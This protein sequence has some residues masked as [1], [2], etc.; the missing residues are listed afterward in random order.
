V[1]LTADATQIGIAIDR[2]TGSGGTDMYEGL[3]AAD[4]EL[5][6][7]ARV[8]VTQLVVLITDGS[9]TSDSVTQATKMK[10]AGVHIMTVGFTTGVD[11]TKLK[12]LASVRSNSTVKD[13]YF[14][15]EA[16][17]LK[18]ITAF[19]AEETCKI[20]EP[21]PI[22]KP[23][24]PP[25]PIPKITWAE[26]VLACVTGTTES[27]A[28]KTVLVDARG[29]FLDFAV[30]QGGEDV[31]SCQFKF[32]TPDKP[33]PPADAPPTAYNTSTVYS[34]TMPGRWNADEVNQIQC[35]TPP[36][37]NW[38][39]DQLKNVDVRDLRFKATLEVLI[40]PFVSSAN[41]PNVVVGVSYVTPFE[42]KVCC[43]F[44][45]PG[46]WYLFTLLPIFILLLILTLCYMYV[47]KE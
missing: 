5:I 43:L 19:V 44:A 41:A 6:K 11:E 37:L 2:T 33:D 35:D 38:T 36:R 7:N 10:N 21:P 39:H 3:K 13:Y 34:V 24:P 46:T 16:S 17:K 1:G 20:V 45:S 23:P 27:D 9:D 26:P 32:T 8:N 30:Q 12:L 29:D 47:T 18:D 22:K 28:A 15:P 40:R 31:F 25:D 42:Y 4:D 14:A